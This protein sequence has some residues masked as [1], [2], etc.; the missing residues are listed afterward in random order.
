MSVEGHETEEN[1]I[2]SL[3][4]VEAHRPTETMADGMYIHYDLQPNRDRGRAK[5]MRH[6]LN[7]LRGP[8]QISITG[9]EHLY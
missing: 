6:A 8:V 1:I 2:Q 5:T 3:S 4:P 7:E 9:G